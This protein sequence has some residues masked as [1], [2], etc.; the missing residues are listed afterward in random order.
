MRDA[1]HYR[2]LLDSNPNAMVNLTLAA[3]AV[4]AA[5]N[6]QFDNGDASTEEWKTVYRELKGKYGENLTPE[7]ARKEME[8]KGGPEPTVQIPLRI[9]ESLLERIE[10]ART[11]T[12]E[13]RQGFIVRVIKKELQ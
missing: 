9:K 3:S 5:R 6:G 12:G 2:Q 11:Q 1:A 7:Q 4:Y 13:S 10:A 8:Q